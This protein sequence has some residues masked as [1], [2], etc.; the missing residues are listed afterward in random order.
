MG[1]FFDIAAYQIF[2]IVQ[3]LSNDLSVQLLEDML[4]PLF[5]DHSKYVAF[6]A[7]IFIGLFGLSL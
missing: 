4:F 3:S 6:L 2:N 5:Y 7:S 1:W